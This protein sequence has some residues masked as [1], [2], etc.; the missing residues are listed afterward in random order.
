MHHAMN[1]RLT[2]GGRNKALVKLPG[3]VALDSSQADEKEGASKYNMRTLAASWG[4]WRSYSSGKRGQEQEF[5]QQEEKLRWEHQA[6]LASEKRYASLC[7]AARCLRL[8]GAGMC[9]IS[10]TELT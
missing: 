5:S 7:A 8:S 4:D 10:R 2:A 3:L 6:R 1:A 9:K